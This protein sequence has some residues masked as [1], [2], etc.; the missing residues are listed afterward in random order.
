MTPVCGDIAMQQLRRGV[1]F[2]CHPQGP[3]ED[4]NYQHPT[5]CLAEGLRELGVEVYA[6]SDYWRECPDSRSCLLVRSEDTGP[7][8][9]DVAVVESAR[10]A[11]RGIPREIRRKRRRLRAVLIDTEDGVRTVSNTRVCRYFDVVLRPHFNARAPYA[12]QN[13]KPWAF[14]LSRRMLTELHN[15]GPWRERHQKIL[16]NYGCLHPLRRRV[17]RTV[18]P[19]LRPFLDVEETRDSEMPADAYHALMWRQTGRRHYPAYYRRL[20]NTAACA[21]FGGLTPPVWDY[22][23]NPLVR[24][25]RYRRE[26]YTQR[27]LT[28]WDSWRLWESLAAG[29]VTFHVDFRKYGLVLPVMPQNWRH[30][31]GVDLDNPQE[32]IDRIRDDPSLLERI[33]A[34][35]REWALAHYSPVATA[36]R[37]LHTVLPE[38]RSS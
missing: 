14:G 23:T 27:V 33:S 17:I 7:E 22:E 9:C 15:P 6:S 36:S 21:A 18:L 10:I 25:R 35:G 38:W 32:A 30:Y 5:V 8:D 37:F 26:G 29:A 19:G 4:A 3:P 34:A 28:Q 20:K 24:F 2:Y 12:S 31:V 13:V 11:E 16:V 1:Y